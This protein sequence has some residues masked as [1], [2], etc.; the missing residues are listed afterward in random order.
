MIKG[1][2]SALALFC[3]GLQTVNAAVAVNVADFG[4]VPNDAKCDRAAIAK[5]VAAAK[6]NGADE[7][8]FEKGVYELKVADTS[9]ERCIEIEGIANLTVSGAT[10]ENGTPATTFQRQFE[11]KPDLNGNQILR[12]SNCPNFTLKNVVFDNSPRY[13]TAGEIISN[14][15]ESI[16][17]RVFDGNPLFDKSLAIC[18]NLWDKNTKNLKKKG[19][20]TF[21]A[22][23]GGNIK[24][25][26]EKYTFNIVG[27]PKDRVVELKNPEI[28]KK[29]EVGEVFS[30]N[31]GWL[32]YQV[33]FMRC[34]NLY[35]ENVRTHSA[36]G[37]CMQASFCRNV[38]AKDVKFLKAG[39]QMHV[40]SRDAWKLMACRGIAVI[41]NM[42]I[43]GVRWDGQN[44]HGIFVWP[45][46]KV[47]AK[48]A[49]FSN[50]LY[51]IS[52]DAFAIGSKVGFMK[53]KEEEL[54]LTIV[55][56]KPSDKLTDAGKKMVI[57]S[58]AEDLP[59]W[60]NPSTTCNLYGMNLDSYVLINSTFKNIA[61]T[62]SLIRNDNASITGCTFDHIMYPAICVGGAMG[63]VEGVVSKNANIMNNTFIACSWQARHGATGAVSA[64]VQQ[65]PRVPAK[66]TPYI[67]DVNISAN[68]F[69]DCDV[70]V[71]TAGV[72]G[73]YIGGN[74]FI[75]TAKPVYEY[76]NAA[77]ILGQNIYDKNSPQPKN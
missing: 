75:N 74:K 18:A 24:N 20:V 14:D 76:D 16:R 27:G 47:D 73:L 69:I 62:A 22:P 72:K 33:I 66:L 52:H 17:V 57:V 10:E 13:M 58:F 54:L 29:C 53:D 39:N 50:D 45:Y 55:S 68:T 56:A 19:S 61:G 64:R 46:E 59:E 43:E 5:A 32:G 8:K 71:E 37:F 11:Y 25:N 38:R 60:V 12:V 1:I 40:G 36:L 49:L 6:Q 34:D 77:V 41:E 31:F 63:E 65:S 7:I 3:V 35:V 70:G 4:A 67:K 26:P 9:K 15:G 51:G 44:V 48:T 21:G 28:A 30:W 42:Y 2:L 23:E